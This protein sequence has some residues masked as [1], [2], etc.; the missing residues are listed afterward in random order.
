M[1]Q[2]EE[3][4]AKIISILTPILEEEEGGDPLRLYE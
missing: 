1:S 3:K 2:S 4:K